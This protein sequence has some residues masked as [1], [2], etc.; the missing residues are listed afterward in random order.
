M[1]EVEVG[2]D[3]FDSIR[4]QTK[5]C[6]ENCKYCCV[7]K[8]GY[9][10]CLGEGNFC[11]VE[12]YGDFRQKP[13]KI[14]LPNVRFKKEIPIDLGNLCDKREREKVKGLSASDIRDSVTRITNISRIDIVIPKE[15]DMLKLVCKYCEGNG[16]FKNGLM[17]M[18]C[19]DCKGKGSIKVKVISVKVVGEK[20]KLEVKND[21]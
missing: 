9:P 21:R 20:V 4:E 7:A 17:D 10:I 14:L 18:T 2:A 16:S 3:V 12:K 19:T 13:I 15:G 1:Q 11:L 6:C 8:E 5:I